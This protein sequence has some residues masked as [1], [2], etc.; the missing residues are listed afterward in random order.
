[1]FDIDQIMNMLDWNKDIKTQKKGIELAKNIKCINAFILPMHPE[2][3]KNVW[4]N[5]AKILADK[6]D[7]ELLP[8]LTEIL[9]WVEDLNWP[10][11]II[12]LERMKKIKEVRHLSLAIQEV[13]S[14]LDAINGDNRKI[15]LMYLAELLDNEKLKDELPINTLITLNET[16]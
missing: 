12:I 1:M 3:N 15:W 8:Y 13:I 4:E 10:G 2:C 14:I 11:A 16:M 9:L 7:E 5:C 6:A